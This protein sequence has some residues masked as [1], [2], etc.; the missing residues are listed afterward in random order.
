MSSSST[1]SGVRVSLESLS[2]MPS[3]PCD[4]LWIG[5]RNFSLFLEVEIANSSSDATVVL[6]ARIVTRSMVLSAFL[7]AESICA[8]SE[9][10]T[11]TFS[12]SLAASRIDSVWTSAIFRTRS[13]TRLAAAFSRP[14]PSSSGRKPFSKEP[15]SLGLATIRS[16]KITD[17]IILRR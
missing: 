16:R 5:M 3:S 9:P 1:C 14:W 10:E 8:V 7:P 17:L 6:G 13:T 12:T 11:L 4:W 2:S 15:S